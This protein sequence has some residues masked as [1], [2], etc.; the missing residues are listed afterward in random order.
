MSSSSNDANSVSSL[1]EL[2]LD[3]TFEYEEQKNQTVNYGYAS[4]KIEQELETTPN[5]AKS[6]GSDIEMFGPT[7]KD[8]C[9]LSEELSS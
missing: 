1:Y 9:D 5:S 2:D 6:M 4:P 7:S 8:V 3:N